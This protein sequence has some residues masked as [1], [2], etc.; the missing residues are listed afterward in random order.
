[1]PWPHQRAAS[2]IQQMMQIAT[3][4]S[5]KIDW[6]AISSVGAMRICRS[7]G[8]AHATQKNGNISGI[9]VA[10]TVKHR[11]GTRRAN[12]QARS[13]QAALQESEIRLVHIAVA[14]E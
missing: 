3:A 6:Y 12:R 10:I 14:I 9:C 13:A 5:R 7:V 1:M 2:L 11:S 8:A 4:S